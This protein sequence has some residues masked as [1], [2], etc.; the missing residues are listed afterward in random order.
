MNSTIQHTLR[1]VSLTT[2]VA[3]S[4][5]LADAGDWIKRSGN[6]TTLQNNANTAE[7]FVVYPQMHGGNC[8]IGIALNRRNSYTDNYQI[9]ADNLVVD[10]YYPNT[11]GSTE[12]S[13]GTQ[14]RAGMTYTFDL[15]TQYY[16]TV[17]TIRTKGGETF[18]ELF[19]K[20]SNNPDVHAVVSAID[21]DQ[22]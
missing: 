13:P 17:V 21:C 20:L 3:A 10:N 9:L 22:I 6:F 15:T 14:T 2:L 11:E 1:A 5:A 12:L 16:G 4:S 19:E 7:L 18:G 8:G